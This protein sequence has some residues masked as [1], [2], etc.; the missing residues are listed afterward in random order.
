[1]NAFASAEKKENRDVGSFEKVALA[2]SAD[3]YLKQES[4]TSVV[5]EGDEKTLE[6]I[7]TYIEKGT[8]KIKYDK[9][10]WRNYK[11]VTIYISSPDYAGVSVSGSGDI[12]AKSD[13]SSSKISFAVS[14][15]GGIHMKELN[16]EVISTQISGSGE[17]NLAASGD[18]RTLSVAISGSGDIDASALMVDEVVVKISGSGGAKVH[19]SS[20]LEVSVSGSGD[21]YYKGNPQINAHISGSGKVRNLK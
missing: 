14:G 20:R 9:W 1:M 5:I 17:I 11:K 21:V 2:I 19:A 18:I 16:A 13:I 15:S 8:L 6:H 12:F 4:E 10:S 3:V 7:K